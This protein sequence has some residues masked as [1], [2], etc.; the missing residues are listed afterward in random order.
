MKDETVQVRL[1]YLRHEI[2]AERISYG[3]IAELQGLA[4]HI[5]EGDVLLREWAG[6]PENS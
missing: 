3:E 5:P 4:D 6:I 2:E 1:N